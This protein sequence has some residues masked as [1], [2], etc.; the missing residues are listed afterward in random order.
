MQTKRERGSRIGSRWISPVVLK[1]H[2]QCPHC[3]TTL[4]AGE[5]YNYGGDAVCGECFRF[6]PKTIKH[7]QVTAR[8][9]RTGLVIDQQ[10]GINFWI[11]TTKEAQG[12][13]IFE[14]IDAPETRSST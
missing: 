10:R 11:A 7:G 5:W 1:S 13:P 9:A 4:Q 2:P 3:G 6:K 12:K 8:L 14:L